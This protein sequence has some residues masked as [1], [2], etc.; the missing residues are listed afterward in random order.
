[1]FNN[2]IVNDIIIFIFGFGISIG[3]NLI[4][5]NSKVWGCVDGMIIF[6]GIFINGMRVEEIKKVGIKNIG[7]G[8]N[9]IINI[10]ID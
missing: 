1:M 7:R 2:F 10:I 9:F 4:I 6:I 8:L 3:E 5:V